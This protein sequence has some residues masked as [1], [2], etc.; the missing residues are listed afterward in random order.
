MMK[1]MRRRRR[2]KGMRSGRRRSRV[3]AMSVDTS[4]ALSQ[5][6][7]A[8]WRALSLVHLSSVPAQLAC[9]CHWSL[10]H[11]TGAKQAL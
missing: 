11:G 10:M 3:A 6:P 5:R 1:T 8:S 4:P 2:R 9:R 7:V